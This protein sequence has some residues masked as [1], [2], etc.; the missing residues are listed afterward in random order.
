M[1]SRDKVVSLA[2]AGSLLLILGVWTTSWWRADLGL[3]TIKIGLREVRVCAEMT[4]CMSL[5]FDAAQSFVDLG[6]AEFIR[7]ARI[8]H[9]SG[10]AGGVLLLA[11]AIAMG[12][13]GE[14]RVGI[15]AAVA[16]VVCGVAIAATIAAKPVDVTDV[17]TVGF[18]PFLAAGGI[19][20]G[21]GSA[22]PALVPNSF[23]GRMLAARDRLHRAAVGPVAELDAPRPRSELPTMRVVDG[24]APLGS[25]PPPSV[26]P[27][28]AARP[29]QP[30]HDPVRFSVRDCRIQ[31][32]GL[33]IDGGRELSWARIQRVVMRELPPDPPF[34]GRVMLDIVPAP[35]RDERVT[36][37][38]ILPETR[39]NYAALPGGADAAARNNLKR[40]ALLIRDQNPGCALDGDP[41]RLATPRHFRDYDAQYG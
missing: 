40:L 37:I 8:A 4:P 31:E 36:P 9:L 6:A 28:G 35:V 12:K 18:S 24:S 23:V 3:A 33:A 26:A 11:H 41:P 29:A 15:A 16:C 27:A 19:A 5:P 38:R 21:I 7:F 1:N 32:H 34:H 17:T 25:P 20:L 10:L 39:V 13:H 14:R 22:V 30:G 2:I